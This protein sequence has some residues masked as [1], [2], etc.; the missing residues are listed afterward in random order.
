MPKPTQG[1]QDDKM[2]C[3][4]IREE[5]K[6]QF[7]IEIR[8]QI[9]K[10]EAKKNITKQKKDNW[11]SVKKKKRKERRYIYIISKVSIRF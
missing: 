3:P 5:I 2:V 6:K 1:S 10:H 11:S 9:L 4:K 7:P 8:W